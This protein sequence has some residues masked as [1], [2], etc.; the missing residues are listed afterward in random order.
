M[1]LRYSIASRIGPDIVTL[2]GVSEFSRAFETKASDEEESKIN[3]KK[4][5]IKIS[6]MK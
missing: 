5:D 4:I 6:K 2:T 1:I 3:L